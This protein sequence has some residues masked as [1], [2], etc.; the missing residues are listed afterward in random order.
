MKKIAELGFVAVIVA[1]VSWAGP[2]AAQKF[3]AQLTGADEVPSVESPAVGR[4]VISVRSQNVLHA[5]SVGNI[6]AISAAHLHCAPEGVN[7]PVG[8]TLFELGD[9]KHASSGS[10]SRGSLPDPDE[11]NSCGWI[12]LDDAID[13]MEAGEVYVNVHTKRFRDGEIRGQLR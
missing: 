11:G 3:V 4:A 1:A 6:V 10:L 5:L 7:G 9:K 8:I 12:T 13:A 2:A